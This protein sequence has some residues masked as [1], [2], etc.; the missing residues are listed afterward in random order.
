M[1][2]AKKIKAFFVVIGTVVNVLFGWCGWLAMA[3]AAL[4]TTDYLL[5]SMAAGRTGTWNSRAARLGVEKKLGY[6]LVCVSAGVL[7]LVI[8]LVLANVPG[9]TLPFEYSVAFLPMVML[10]YIITELGSILENADAL[11]AKTPAFLKRAMQLMKAEF[12]QDTE[13]PPPAQTPNSNSDHT[14]K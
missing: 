10:W 4:M 5:G 9:I 8:R 12:P 14:E 13:T 7:D 11:G 3:L 1:E 6:L 2:Q